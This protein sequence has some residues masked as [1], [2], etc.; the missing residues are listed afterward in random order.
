MQ[1][2]SGLRQALISAVVFCGVMLALASVDPR[3]GD[4]MD[5][6]IYS[7]DGVSSW[8]NRAAELGHALVLAVRHQSIDNAP[9]M[10]FAAVG[11]VLFVFMVRA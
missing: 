5:N 8:D 3:V 6:L 1:I 10:I 2:K 9:M 7:G 4:Q 11:A